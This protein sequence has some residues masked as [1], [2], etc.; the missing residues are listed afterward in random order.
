METWRDIEGYEGIYQVSDLGNVRSVDRLDAAN[1]KI[2]GRAMRLSQRRTKYLQLSLSA[3]GKNKKHMVHRLVAQA[4]IPNP[5]SKSDVN[6][7][8]GVKDD[9]RLS[10]LEWC[11][12]KENVDHAIRTGLFRP[13]GESGGNAKL[14]E[15]DVQHIRWLA[16]EGVKQE[17][18]AEEWGVTRSGIRHVVT[19]RTWSHV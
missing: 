9:N 4:F 10:N 17:V 6:H 3:E 19:G 7:V 12:H 2:K 14:T 18:L 8:N 5:Y 15:D 13:V 11:T 1:H 16:A